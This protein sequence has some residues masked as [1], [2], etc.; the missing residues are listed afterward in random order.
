MNGNNLENL[1]KIFDFLEVAEKLKSTLRYNKT[2]SG[3]QESTAEHSWRLALMIFMLAD[4]LK[5]EIDV[6]RAVKIALVHDLAEALTGDIDA[7]LIAEGKISKEEKEI[8][9]ARAVE[10]IQQTLP[11]LVGKE[12]TALQNEYNENK[13]R[14][15]KFVKALDKIETLTQLAESGYKIY[16]KPEFIANY[17]DKAVG[18][19]PELLE[20]LKIVKRK[21]KIEF[22][23]GNIQWKKE[24]DNFCLT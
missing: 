2:T 6:S 11:A 22:K 21:L 15:A 9:E 16:D 17:A 12:I 23:K 10:K 5:L 24:Y 7:I 1:E 14:E 20:T 4:E 8:Q 13:T 18:E 19:F 3:R